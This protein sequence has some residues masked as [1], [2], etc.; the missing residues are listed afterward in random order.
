LLQ[1]SGVSSMNDIQSLFKE[2][3]CRVHGKRP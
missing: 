2:N 1:T 3:H